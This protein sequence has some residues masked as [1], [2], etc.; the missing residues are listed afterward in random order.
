MMDLESLRLRTVEVTD[1]RSAVAASAF[2]LIESTFA[3][4]DRHSIEELRAEVAEKRYEILKPFDYHLLAA[5]D[6]EERVVAVAV[7]VYLAGV[8]AGFVDYLVVREDVRGCGVGHVL[9]EQLAAAFAANAEEAGQ[10][11]LAAVLGEVREDNPW[12]LRLVRNGR[13]VPLHLTYYHPALPLGGKRYILYRQ[14]VGDRRTE[15]PPAEVGQMLYA[16]YRRAYRVRYPLERETF[17]AML[18]ELASRPTVGAH[19][20]VVQRAG[21]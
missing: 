11:P 8:N 15:F 6:S 10:A 17:R 4:Q 14:P 19:P 21:A 16:I 9:R 7:G 18:E 20:D 1:E 3:R 12:L 13:A 5:V 2:A